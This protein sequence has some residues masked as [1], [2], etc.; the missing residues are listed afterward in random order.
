MTPPGRHR[1]RMVGRRWHNQHQPTFSD[2][3]AAVRRVFRIIAYH[4]SIA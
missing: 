2:A 3:I 4:Q 1:L